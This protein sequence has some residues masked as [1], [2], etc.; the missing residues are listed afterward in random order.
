MLRKVRHKQ[1]YSYFYEPLSF[2][3]SEKTTPYYF[4]AS[5]AQSLE[6]MLASPYQLFLEIG[7]AN[8]LYS[9]Q[10]HVEKEKPHFA[11]CMTTRT[12]F[13]SMVAFI[14]SEMLNRRF[15][16]SQKVVDAISTSLHET[17]QNAIVHGNL[18]IASHFI[19]GIGLEQH[20]EKI[21]DTLK[22]K[23]LAARYVTICGWFFDRMI[24]LSVTDQGGG[25]EIETEHSVQQSDKPHGRGIMLVQELCGRVW[26][27]PDDNRS[28]YMDFTL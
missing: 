15:L 9:A 23:E 26:M 27:K 24:R 5:P 16:L 19:D 10:D 21:Q 2:T 12:I 8:L 11:L 14:V 25:F 28:I 4:I 17:I 6:T 7:Q 22:N 13:L 18:G 1:Y 20:Y 3:P